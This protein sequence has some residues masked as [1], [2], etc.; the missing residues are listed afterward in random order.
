[1]PKPRKPRSLDLLRLDRVSLVDKGDNPEAHIM[2]HKR[3]DGVE[4]AIQRGMSFQR[5]C[6][7]VEKAVQAKWGGEGWAYCKE[8]FDDAV[9]FEQGGKQWL[10]PYSM[11]ESEGE[12]K[13]SLGDREQAET[14]Y[15]TQK[16]ESMTAEQIMQKFT[17]LEGTLA[18]TQ[19]RAERAEAI[20]KLNAAERAVFEKLDAAKQDEYLAGDATVREKLAESVK[21]A[22]TEPTDIEKRLAAQEAE[23]VSLAKRLAAA[24]EE[25]ELARY[26]KR[27]TVEIPNTPGTDD[28]KGRMLRAVDKIADAD[29]RKAALAALKAGDAALATLGKQVGTAGKDEPSGAEAKLEA[30]VAK[31]AAEEK[32]SV[33]KAWGIVMDRHPELYREYRAEK[34]RGVN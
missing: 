11:E 1:M 25:A 31:I 7:E 15:E 14:V 16:G 32:V 18:E 3:A 28:E 20:T 26:A 21:P 2:I 29:A 8:T 6:G 22:K 10:A 23:N 24:E 4:K 5:R 34:G 19:K 13:V 17:A 33:S 12:M 9:V 30:A 27:A